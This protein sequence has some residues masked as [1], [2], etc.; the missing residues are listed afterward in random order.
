MGLHSK[1]EELWVEAVN[2]GHRIPEDHILRKIARVLDL[3]FVREAVADKYGRN[4]HV[5]LD[6]VI[7]VKLMLLLFLDNVKS[8]RELMRVIPLRIDYLWFL[9]YGLDDTIPNHS[10]L[11]KA[12]RRWGAEVFERLFRETVRQ[13]LDA[14]LIEGEKVHVDSSTIRANASKNSIVETLCFEHFLAKLEEEKA[15]KEEAAEEEPA[16]E[17]EEGGQDQESEA[18]KPKKKKKRYKAGEVNRTRKSTTDPEATL[19][20]RGR[21]DSVPSYKSHRLVDN[22]VGVISAIATTPSIVSEAHKLEELIEQHQA[23]IGETVKTAVADTLYGTAENFIAL[24]QRGIRTHMGDLRSRQKNHRLKDI[25]PTEAF[26]YN[27]ES[28]TYTCPAGKS[29][30]YRHWNSKRHYAEYEGRAA[31]CAACPLRQRC[32]RAKKGRTVNRRP[33]QELLDKARRESA[34]T[35]GKLDRKRRQH[36]MEGSFADATNHHGFKRSRWRGLVRQSIQ[37]YMIAAVQNIRL[38]F[39]ATR[40]KVTAAA[41]A[42][43]RESARVT[44]ALLTPLR[45]LLPPFCPP[46][47]SHIAPLRPPFGLTLRPC[48]ALCEQVA[49]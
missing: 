9:G 30:H 14:G 8:E 26:A 18:Q 28:D 31:E 20:G 2:L 21:G 27:K 22:K 29:L 37:D 42:L 44:Q 45:A 49:P 1:Q 38:L 7:I 40:Q 11:S 41:L 25:F 39:K 10:V 13:C 36:L 48:G 5:S 46:L 35:L 17:G 6:P 47:A 3:G 4:G 24:Q 34:S 33:E 32:T 15:K 23:N 19:C 16:E 43:P 12:R